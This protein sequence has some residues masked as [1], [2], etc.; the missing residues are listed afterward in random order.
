M[1]DWNTIDTVLLDMDGTLLDLHFDNYF[2]LTHLPQRY[3]QEHNTSLEAATAALTEMIESR[4]GTLQW[5]CLDHWSELVKMDI[6]ALKR[7]I[8]H[9]I[10]IRPYTEQFLQALKAMGKKVVLITNAHPTGLNLKLDV[11]RIDQWLD[12]VISSHEFQSPKED[13]SF[14]QQLSVREAFD[15]ARTLFIDDTARILKSAQDFGIAHLVCINQ[16]DSQKPIVRSET[17][18]DIVHFDEIMPQLKCEK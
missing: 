7:E 11:T 14:W 6:P 12:I 9:K 2:W 18:T 10:A 15:P 16:P 5:Y 8:Q 3:A 1:I 4:V 13:A 17:F